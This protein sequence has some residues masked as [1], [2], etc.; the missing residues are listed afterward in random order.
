MIIRTLLSCR[1]RVEYCD[2]HVC[3]WVCVCVCLHVYHGNHKS[4]LKQ[5]FYI[6]PLA[7]PRSSFRS[8][9]IH[10]VLPVLWM[11]SCLPIWIQWLHVTT[12]A[13]AVS[14]QCCA[15]TRVRTGQ[16]IRCMELVASGNAFCPRQRRVGAVTRWV[17]H[18]RD[19]RGRVCNA[20]LACYYEMSTSN[21]LSESATMNTTLYYSTCTNSVESY[22]Q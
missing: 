18:A 15:Q 19:T 22:V 2:E 6:L 13:A 10:Y 4:K 11:M 5:I 20:S 12:A 3:L 14:L 17:I 7:M 1:R 21:K 9:A 16:H 8:T